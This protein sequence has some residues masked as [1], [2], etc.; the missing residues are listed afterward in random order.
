MKNKQTKKP[1][2]TNKNQKYWE[3]IRGEKKAG[4]SEIKVIL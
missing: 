1:N 2:Q 3:E 4:Q